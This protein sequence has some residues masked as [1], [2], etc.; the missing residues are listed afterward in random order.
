VI[1]QSSYDGCA[2]IWSA[3]ITAIE[4]AKGAPPYANKIHPFQVI[5]LI[6]K[7]PPPKLEG[8][9]SDTFK[10][11]VAC[12]LK[13]S[14]QERPSAS[15]LLRHPFVSNAVRTDR[16]LG[17]IK[18]KVQLLWQLQR[19][20]TGAG[21]DTSSGQESA[22]QVEDSNIKNQSTPGGLVDRNISF[23]AN[24]PKPSTNQ[25]NNLRGSRAMEMSRDMDDYNV[26]PPNLTRSSRTDFNSNNFNNSGARGGSPNNSMMYR[27]APSD[28]S[29]NVATTPSSS[30]KR[31]NS[32]QLLRSPY[33]S[34][35]NSVSRNRFAYNNAPNNASNNSN[36]NATGWNM[37][38]DVTLF[39]QE[40]AR[41]DANY[42]QQLEKLREEVNALKAANTALAERNKPFATVMNLMSIND[43]Y[44]I[45][46]PSDGQ[47]ASPS[48]L[49]RKVSGSS[50]FYDNAVRPALAQLRS[51]L[52]KST[53][54][55]NKIETEFETAHDVYNV[56]NMSLAA[57]D[58]ITFLADKNSIN[59]QSYYHPKKQQQVKQHNLYNTGVWTAEL[60]TVM[61]SYLL[62][63]MDG[64]I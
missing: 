22:M 60:L 17:L 3:G 52:D 42:E 32:M 20:L 46:I 31:S 50:R 30:F 64:N 1:T 41:S 35:Y 55:G 53:G 4:L 59:S 38:F 10:D 9:F 63:E 16:W 37:G 26:T 12:C 48:D 18:Q 61:S 36:S 11:F 58:A 6:P 39:E 49:A 5:F 2:D 8:D 40:K 15:E 57:L 51:K 23:D 56:L 21:E 47:P 7:S 62:E 29:N 33:A 24:S 13:K 34:P 19:E 14:A 27:M 54:G 25:N 43:H 28:S 44:G 45:N